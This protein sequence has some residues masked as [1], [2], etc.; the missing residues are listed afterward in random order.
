MNNY[1]EESNLLFKLVRTEGFRFIIVKY[2]HYSLV[3]KLKEDLKA[4]FPNR[5]SKEI[6]ATKTDYRNLVDSYYELESGFFFIENF[7][8]L[9]ENPEIYPALNQRRDKLA[10]YPIAMIAFISP[11][12]PK[13]FVRELMEKMP[14]LWSFRSLMLEL[15]KDILIADKQTQF[16]SNQENAI[17]I[18]SLGGNTV[19]EKLQEIKRLE[20][21][22]A[23]NSDDIPLREVIL[24]QLA[25][26]YRDIGE[27]EKS[28]E[29]IDE[30]L[31]INTDKQTEAELL[32][33]K[34][35]NYTVLGNLEKALLVFEKSLKIRREIENKEKEG[36]VLERLGSTHQE[37]G[38]T[39]LALNY[40]EKYNDLEKQLYEQFPTNINFKNGLAISYQY[41]GRIHQE[42]EN[43]KLALEF[44]EKQTKLFEQLYNEFPNN[45]NFKNG[46]AISYIKLGF[47]F[48]SIQNVSKAKNYYLKSK[49]HYIELTE[50]FP[51]YAEFQNN[52]NW[53]ED[54]LNQL[55]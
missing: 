39:K 46:L 32:V 23:E 47:Y 42:L 44:F 4:R 2:N 17:S 3:E 51:S 30:L 5:K 37:L 9:L 13:L 21:L 36:I 11:S 25:T 29:I 20:K 7:D 35:D 19:E 1:Q 41:L 24:S 43:I 14:D 49:K 6:D 45:V 33:D 40:F 50:E 18:S 34:G 15:E 10:K 38:N 26:L 54:K 12:A 8:K 28:N 31:K 48:E 53:V 16:S 27:Y 55:Q 22:L 52:L